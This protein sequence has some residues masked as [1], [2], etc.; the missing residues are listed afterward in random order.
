MIWTLVRVFRR[1][2]SMCGAGVTRIVL[3][4]SGS[5]PGRGTRILGFVYMRQPRSIRIGENCQLGRRLLVGSELPNTSLVIE[6]GVQVNDEVQLDHTGNLKIERG[7]LISAGAL[8]Y[9]HDHGYDPRSHPV[10]TTKC[11]G[12]YAWIGT[13]AIILPTC[14]RIGAHAIVGAG[15]VVAKDVPDFAVVA[16]NPA[17]VV[18]HV[19]KAPDDDRCL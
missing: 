3:M 14:R 18:S 1:V 12:P 17:K 2:A 4:S 16:G 11:I 7:A 9:T 19:A 13:R 10:P 5:A 15:A 8:I 6:D